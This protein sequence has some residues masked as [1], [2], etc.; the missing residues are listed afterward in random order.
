[1]KLSIDFIKVEDFLEGKKKKKSFMLYRLILVE[2]D[3]QALLI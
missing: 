3:M 1:M 2:N